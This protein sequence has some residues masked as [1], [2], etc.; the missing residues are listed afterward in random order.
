MVASMTF[1]EKLKDLRES[2][3]LS[4]VE[5]A[6]RAG[7]TQRAISGWETGKREPLWSA[8]QKLATA[9]GVSPEALTDDQHVRPR[10][11]K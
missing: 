10:K 4:Q 3:K 2:A 1:A 7:V 6:E 9:L 8:V 11:K 5:L